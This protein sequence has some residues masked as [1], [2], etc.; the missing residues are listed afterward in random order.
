MAALRPAEIAGLLDERFRLL[1]RG[2]A[3]AADRQQTLQATVEWSYALLGEAERRVFGCLGVFPGSF[4]AAAATAVAGAAG[5]QQWDALDSLTDLVSKSM[6]AEEEGLDQTSRYR[7][8]ETMQAYARQQL[9]ADELG[10][11]RHRHAEHYAAFAER[12]GLE[13]LGPAQLEWQQRIRAE[14]D[15]LQ[16]A[17]T[18]ALTSGD[19][20]RP[21]GLPD[22]GRPGS[23]RR[24]IA[25]YRRRLGRSLRRPDRRVPARV[26]RNGHRR[27]GM[28]RVL[29]Q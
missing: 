1:T 15:N 24:H 3:D 17:V 25:Q 2:R 11:L 18:W 10:R 29:R 16:A 28:D 13:L 19:Q 21:L 6:V 9:A 26:A 23:L 14:R 5:L 8:L 12:A 27:G 20:A 22:R 4:D 7:L